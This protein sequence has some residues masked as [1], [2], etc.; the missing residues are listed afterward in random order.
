MKRIVAF[1]LLIALFISLCACG[2][3]KAVKAAEEAISSIGEVTLDSEEA[4]NQAQKHF[5]ILTE[6][7]KAKVDNR[8][9]LVEAI[10]AYETAVA[11]RAA[12]KLTPIA[13]ELEELAKEDTSTNKEFD[14][15]A[16][17]T[18]QW[19]TDNIEGFLNPATVEM[20]GEAYY[21][22]GETPG[23]FK[24]LLVEFRADNAM[25][26]K[27]VGY[28]KVTSSGIHD[29]DWQ[30]RLGGYTFEGEQVWKASHTFRA[31]NAFEEFMAN[32]YG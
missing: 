25:G 30:P 27:T 18:Y 8:L 32:N 15:L 19:V 14:Y 17:V 31:V 12:E 6:D 1:L 28:S 5:D 21:C 3:S 7:E 20:T 11:A 29:T 4:I 24:F 9:V 16:W 13:D 22:V 2:K 23:E 26:G 10:E